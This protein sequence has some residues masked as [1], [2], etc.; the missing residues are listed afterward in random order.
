VA[1]YSATDFGRGIEACPGLLEN[2][3]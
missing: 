3:E 1:M 2:G